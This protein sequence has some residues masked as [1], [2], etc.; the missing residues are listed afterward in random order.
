[1]EGDLYGYESCSS[2]WIFHTPP[3]KGA[4]FDHK[5]VI[6]KETVS[7]HIQAHDGVDKGACVAPLTLFW[8]LEPDKELLHTIIDERDFV[9]RHE[10]VRAHGHCKLLSSMPGLIAK[11]L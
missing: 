1:M 11:E 8:A 7:I 6:R 4:K 10:A 3:W 9:I 5:V 2:T